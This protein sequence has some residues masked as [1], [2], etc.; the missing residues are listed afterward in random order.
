MILADHVATFDAARLGETTIKATKR[1]LSDGIGV[2]LAAS[3]LS[4]DIAPFVGLARNG[5]GGTASL[6]G[7]DQR[8]QPALAALAN[9]AMA[10]ALDY[11]DA[12]D[13]V[14]CH[15]NAALI[16]ALLAVA[17]AVGPVPGRELLAAVALGCDLACR[18]ALAVGRPLEEGGWYPPPIFGG[19]G[20]VAAAARILRL[21]ARQTADAFSLMLLQTCPGEIK[22]AP[23]TVLRA[24]REAF[25]ARA[26]VE[27][28]LLAKGG[29]RGFDRPFE[30]TAGFFRLYSGGLFDPAALT[31]ALGARFH[32]E[33]LS[34]KRWPACRGT[35]AYIETAQRLRA[36]IGDW[37][38]IAR[39]DIEGGP[40][41]V[42][43]AEPEASKKR[44]STAID[45]KFSLPFTVAST[46]V[47]G[48]IGLASFSETALA[49]DQVL[50]LA[51]RAHFT[52]RADWTRA[53]AA[54]SRLAIT[55]DDGT[56]LV[57]EEMVALG[58]PKRPLSDQ[59]LAGKFRQCAGLAARPWSEARATAFL[60]A[61]DGLDRVADS[62]LALALTEA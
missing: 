59:E 32:I 29:V 54:S 34:F 17:E 26:A 40:D 47:H 6:L 25:P 22:Y 45:A 56:T 33:D 48:D 46:F 62:T 3:G 37:R 23:E 18:L 49:D 15:P 58:G 24:V 13:P 43:L 19:F 57:A 50:A 35:H 12:F 61:V 14:P 53:H 28:A 11:E 38:R 10:H 44:P 4:R 41:Q 9:G 5:G 60:G 36:T 2:M 16:P 7:H 1:A 21:D 42:M 20:A 30:G 31:E 51:A 55:L 8:V 39:I 52:R 27:A